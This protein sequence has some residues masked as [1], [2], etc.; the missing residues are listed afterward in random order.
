MI[1]LISSESFLDDCVNLPTL[2]IE[3]F[4]SLAF[5]DQSRLLDARDANGCTAL[6]FAASH[7]HY[8]LAK[9]L[10]ASGADEDAQ[11]EHGRTPLWMASLHGHLRVVDLLLSAGADANAGDR[12]GRNPLD[13]ALAARY[14]RIAASL[15]HAGGVT[16]LDHALEL[17]QRRAAS[18][19]ALSL[20]CLQIPD[21]DILLFSDLLCENASLAEL[22]LQH[23]DA[24][25]SPPADVV[26]VDQ[27]AYCHPTL[28]S[29]TLWRCTLTRR[30]CGSLASGVRANNALS[31]LRLV[32]VVLS[33]GALEA[34]VGGLREECALTTLEIRGSKL[35]DAA[36]VEI[37]EMVCSNG[38]LRAL[39]LAHNRF[40]QWVG[41]AFAQCLMTNTTLV[42]LDLTHSPQLDV[43]QLSF[44]SP[45]T[46][47]VTK[48]M[49]LFDLLINYL[50]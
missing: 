19:S 40:S 48:N 15:A 49:T 36:A 14:E 44:L 24:S 5:F 46:C 4:Q 27:I 35:G 43:T 31:T 34:L 7:G 26:A 42:H 9:L 30:L 47:H 37:A 25:A 2:A 23:L 11:G 12:N 38:G 32:Q 20:D 8:K 39:N 16:Y 1:S 13:V 50:F 17:L 28:V 22:T 41:M 45:N 3:T 21:C 10:L 18:L 33:E 29:L 6:W